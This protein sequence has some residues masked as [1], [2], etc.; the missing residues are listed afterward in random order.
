MRHFRLCHDEQVP[1]YNKQ[2]ITDLPSPPS[3]QYGDG[4]GC[5]LDPI[6]PICY[7]SQDSETTL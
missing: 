3:S 1:L 2:A 7:Y 6:S 5:H 4:G